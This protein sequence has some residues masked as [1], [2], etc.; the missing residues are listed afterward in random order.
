MIYAG[1]A[2]LAVLLV[3]A[4]LVYRRFAANAPAAWQ[5]PAGQGVKTL[6]GGIAGVPIAGG[7][8]AGFLPAPP[9]VPPLGGLTIPHG[10]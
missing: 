8:K 10:Y 6:A 9:I 5:R 2:I 1:A 4:Y 7:I 3:V